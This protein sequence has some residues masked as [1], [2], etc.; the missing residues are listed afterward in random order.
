MNS[1]F[2]QDVPTKFHHIEESDIPPWKRYHSFHLRDPDKYPS[3][4]FVLALLSLC[5]GEKEDY[6]YITESVYQTFRSHPEYQIRLA[7]YI[8]PYYKCHAWELLFAPWSRRRFTQFVR[9]LI[10]K[11]YV[12]LYDM[13]KA[14]AHCIHKQQILL[15]TQ[16]TDYIP[17]FIS[18]TPP[19]LPTMP[20]HSI[21]RPPGSVQ[22]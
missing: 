22:K 8:C 10:G 11:Y 19:P 17:H 6:F 16:Y 2:L 5:G 9:H 7:R 20:P 1:V 14:D 3:I 21:G 18:P 13:P 4:Y 12:P 15:P